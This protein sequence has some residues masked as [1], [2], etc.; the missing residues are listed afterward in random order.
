[1]II[2][3]NRSKV[4]KNLIPEET[5]IE[6]IVQVLSNHQKKDNP[7]GV[8]LLQEICTKRVLVQLPR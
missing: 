7:V 1:M 2:E 6:Y 8:H 5:D 4:K 3:N